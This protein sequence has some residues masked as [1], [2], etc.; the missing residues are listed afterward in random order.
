M[1]LKRIGLAFCLF[2]IPFR[3]HS[4]QTT[5]QNPQA[6][7][8]AMGAIAALTGTTQVRDVTLTGIATRTAG[9][10]IESGG[11]T[12]RA[13][14][15]TEARTDLSLTSGALTEMR[16]SS[17]GSPQ[18]FWI[19]IDGAV[20]FMA[21]QN[22]LTD[23]AWFFPALTGLSQTSNPNLSITYVGQETKNGVSVQHLVF[24]YSAAQ[25]PGIIKPVTGL[26]STDVYLDSSSLLPVAFAFNLHPDSSA[27]INIGVEVDFSNYQAV[28]GVQIPFHIQKFM[29]GTLFLDVTIQSAIL[30]SGLADAVF[31]PN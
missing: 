24:V 28:N 15:T 29:N 1:I 23:A 7:A 27:F 8:L 11:V 9:S 5:A 4:Q 25:T 26:G 19:G 18:G 6:V 31:S 13:L 3:A 10:D 20:H 17:N 16:N 2:F 22:C 21:S 14:G 12:L 30:N